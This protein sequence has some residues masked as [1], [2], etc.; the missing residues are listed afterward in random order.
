M[1]AGDGLEQVKAK[2]GVSG[3]K[4]GFMIVCG[5]LVFTIPKKFVIIRIQGFSSFPKHDGPKSAHDQKNERLPEFVGIL[6]RPPCFQ[7]Y[8]RDNK[9]EGSE[10]EIDNND[11]DFEL[12]FVH[13]SSCK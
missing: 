9:R 7:K 12:F 1:S 13:V 10:D 3:L 11:E 6:R 8:P 5:I 4:T 2:K